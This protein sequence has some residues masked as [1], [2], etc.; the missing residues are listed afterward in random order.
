MNILMLKFRD[1][2]DSDEM[3]HS[4]SKSLNT[5]TQRLLGLANHL[6]EK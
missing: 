4:S 3:K 6:L 1:E 5:P 2:E